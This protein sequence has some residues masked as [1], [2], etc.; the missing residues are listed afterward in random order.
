VETLNELA[1][2]IASAPAVQ[3]PEAL[4]VLQAIRSQLPTF[5]RYVGA[6]ATTRDRE[7]ARIHNQTALAASVTLRRDVMQLGA[8][9]RQFAHE[10]QDALAG[11]FRWVVL[12]LAIVFLAVI[13]L[14]AVVLLRTAGMILKPVDRLVEASRHLAV[15]RFDHRVTLD[16]HD[17]FDELAR[18]Y[19]HLAAQLQANE[20]RKMEVLQQV[21]LAMN[22]ELNNAMAI[23]ELQLEL[24]S[25]QTHGEP[26]A[27]KCLKQIRESL[28]RM[29]AAVESLKHVRRIVL[30]DYVTGVKMLDLEQ[31]VRD[32]PRAG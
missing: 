32:G 28:R 24:M 4:A 8:L 30:T 16:Q 5:E 3:R 1:G 7:L 31:S 11:R 22:H 15:E 14:A 2:R 10:E 20:Q 27:E 13:N 29:D 6:V 26:A 23:I 12:G 19:N 25:R 18:A 9:V 17:E 21:A